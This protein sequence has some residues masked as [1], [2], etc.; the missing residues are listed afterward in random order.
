[1][2]STEQITQEI[3]DI[4]KEFSLQKQKP[5]ITI[6]QPRRSIKE[7][8][9]Q[10][11]QSWQNRMV[12]LTS[13]A[14]SYHAIDGNPVDSARCYLVE[15]A[16]ED[17]P[18]YILF[19][20]EDTALPFN[21]VKDLIE[22]SK[23]FPDAII[24][25]IYYVKFGN[26]M[27]SVKDS[28]DR[29]VLPDVTPN[30]GIIRD[31]MSTGLGCALIPM[32]VIR[33]MQ[34]QFQDL[35]LFCIVPEKTWKDE[36]VTFLGE[37]TWF[38]N[39]A[40]KCGIETIADTRVHCLHIELKTGK[41]AAHP[42]VVLDDYVTNMPVTEPLTMKDRARVSKDYMDRICRPSTAMQQ[43]EAEF[44][45][46]L[47]VVTNKKLII[48]V[49]TAYGGTLRRMME[50]AADDA[51]F[52]SVDMYQDT[53]DGRNKSTDDEMQS[54]KKSDQ[55]L[56]IIRADSHLPETKAE[57]MRILGDRKP[58]FVFID[59]DHSYT[60]VKQDFADYGTLGGIVAFHDIQKSDNPA[61][62]VPQLWAEL[63]ADVPHDHILELID[64]PNQIGFG[65]GVILPL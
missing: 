17:D 14:V 4:A 52:I 10:Q 37:D 30:S 28:E 25:G 16:L 6:L 35:P 55:K 36:D 27:L 29:W 60:G 61:M 15:K 45:N 38:Y 18:M 51:E 7:T 44:I 3:H 62:G 64:N 59:G 21:G 8:P 1:M 22:T 11:L 23:Q 41:Y 54:W 31:I 40:K 42:D 39:L 63:K 47:A 5:Y 49:G 13:V 53:Q 20:D 43:L 12:D 46:L 9:A 48:E 33:K 65:I 26:P 24:S 2:K 50:V 32:S 34:A 56:H 58:D 19:V 57:V